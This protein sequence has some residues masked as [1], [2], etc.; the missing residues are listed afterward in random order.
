MRGEEEEAERWRLEGMIRRAAWGCPPTPPHW[1]SANTDGLSRLATTLN[2][3]GT[4]LW[5]IY[6]RRGEGAKLR[7]GRANAARDGRSNLVAMGL[8]ARGL[9]H[10]GLSEKGKE[11]CRT[12]DVFVTYLPTSMHARGRASRR[13]LR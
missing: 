6:N 5:P 8:P 9:G 1:D 7:L 2:Y 11:V 10:L 12:A 4:R 3:S 13:A